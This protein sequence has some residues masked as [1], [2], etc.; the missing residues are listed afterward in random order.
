MSSA[1]EIVF[2]IKTQYTSNNTFETVSKQIGGAK[3]KLK[4]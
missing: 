2:K 3:K 4:N 1:N